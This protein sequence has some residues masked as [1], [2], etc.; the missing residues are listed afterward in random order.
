MLS[1]A[2]GIVERVVLL[3]SPISISDESWEKARKVPKTSQQSFL[4]FHP[5]TFIVYH[6]MMQMVAGR[7]VNAYSSNDWTLGVTFRAKY[8]LTRRKYM[9]SIHFWRATNHTRQRPQG[10]R[11]ISNLFLMHSLLSKGLAGI[12]SVD[13]HGIENV[14]YFPFYAQCSYLFF[15]DLCVKVPFFFLLLCRS[16]WHIL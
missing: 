1:Y 3:G 13:I 5:W 2:A 4:L 7:F 14:S 12:Q 11:F 9:I 10:R 15:K 6:L 8:V 16:M